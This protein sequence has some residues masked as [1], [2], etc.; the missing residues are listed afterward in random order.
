MSQYL[1]VVIDGGDASKALAP[2]VYTVDTGSWRVVNKVPYAGQPFKFVNADVSN[3][4]LVESCGNFSR[5]NPIKYKGSATSPVVILTEIRKSDGSL[6][7]YR[8]IDRAGVIFV[9]SV[10]KLLL[11]CESI[12]R[13]TGAS[14][15]QNGIYR[16][17]SEGASACIACF[18]GHPF[19]TEILPSIN[20]PV[21]PNLKAAPSINKPASPDLETVLANIR[22][23]VY[24]DSTLESMSTV[25]LVNY[26]TS[27]LH[28]VLKAQVFGYAAL[29]EKALPIY[30][31]F[32]NRC[33]NKTIRNIETAVLWASLDLSTVYDH[34]VPSA[35][36]MFDSK[37]SEKLATTI[38]SNFL[39][40][41][42]YRHIDP[43][44]CELLGV[45]PANFDVKA[46]ESSVSKP[47]TVSSILVTRI[48]PRLESADPVSSSLDCLASALYDINPFFDEIVTKATHFSDLYSAVDKIASWALC[49]PSS[50]LQDATRDMLISS[51]SD[52]TSNPA[53]GTAYPLNR[54]VS[55]LSA[56]P[57]FTILLTKPD[58]E[59]TTSAVPREKVGPSDEAPSFNGLFQ[60]APA[61]TC[62]LAQASSVISQA[63]SILR[64]ALANGVYSNEGITKGADLVAQW[65]L[66]SPIAFV[67][68][69]ALDM[70]LSL[71]GKHTTTL[72]TSL[73]SS[74]NVSKL[75][76]EVDDIEASARSH[77]SEAPSQP[78]KSP[79]EHGK[80]GQTIS[81]LFSSVAPEGCP[82]EVYSLLL[83]KALTCFKSA[84]AN[85]TDDVVDVASA[86]EI[87]ADWVLRLEDTDAE[88]SVARKLLDLCHGLDDRLISSFSACPSIVRLLNEI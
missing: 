24:P 26:L 42:V 87:V 22:K 61:D 50:Q 80:L 13:A 39:H 82:Q 57:S 10:D 88:R 58:A 21:S 62:S 85:Q 78:V 63:E 20:K 27:F 37:T 70:L 77:A 52:I 86:A 9:I 30:I 35:I 36:C 59:D 76:G 40:I 64:S 12:K 51:L 48:E 25:N 18:A 81:V 28:L 74:P 53:L 54:A 34:F 14:Y 45:N 19:A 47:N 72:V 83:D 79:S 75:V 46:P 11:R 73:A 23:Q 31:G 56:L 2:C 69:A 1:F 32:V 8:V 84:L 17:A 67:K 44:I 29:S 41:N 15:I 43:E 66:S 49:S 3:G 7:S 33:T 6:A 4:H 55:A 71:D 16:C 38:L 68:Q 60:S 65:A 5:L